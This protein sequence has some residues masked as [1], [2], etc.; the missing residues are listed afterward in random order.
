M[1]RV[2]IHLEALHHNLVTIDGWM[3]QHG[4]TW[5]VVTKVLC[6]HRETLRALHAFGAKSIGESRLENLRVVVEE[7]PGAETWYLRLPHLSAIDEI[8][9]LSDVSLNSETRSIRALNEAAGRQGKIHRVIIMIELGDLREG[10]LPGSLV[11]F[12]EEVFEL[13]NIEVLGIG[14]NLGCLAGALPNIDQFMQLV[15]YRELLELKFGRKLASLSAGA[16]VALPLLLEG[17]LPRAINHFRI[18]EAIF[19]GTDLVNGESLPGLRSDTV[20]LEA[21][22]IEIKEK[23]LNTTAE[24]GNHTPFAFDFQEDISPGQRGYRALVSVGNLETE[25]SGLTPVQPDFHI[26]GASSDVTVVNVGGDIHGLRV[27]NKIEFRPNY[28]AL[29]R[30]MSGKY[31]DRV[32]DPALADYLETIPGDRQLDIP[33]VLDE[34]NPGPS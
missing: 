11:K 8:V 21:E 14:S 6:G 30:L 9:S 29:L 12:Y 7:M 13:P 28:A 3:K 19:L 25:V 34:L 26:A 20:T 27:G 22:V 2:V 5:T 4:A 18:G 24:T 10:I 31:V 32:V 1:N 15:L 17:K 33:P 16:S 23:S